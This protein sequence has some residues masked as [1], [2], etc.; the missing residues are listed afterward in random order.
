MNTIPH[1]MVHWTKGEDPTRNV[2][3]PDK[4][5]RGHS[6]VEMG[7]SSKIQ[8][9]SFYAL[10]QSIGQSVVLEP[11]HAEE[12][13]RIMGYMERLSD[14]VHSELPADALDEFTESIYNDISE[15]K[16]SPI[17]SSTIITVMMDI[18]N[19]YPV[20]CDNYHETTRRVYISTLM[21]IW[22]SCMF[23][24]DG[25]SGFLDAAMA[26]VDVFVGVCFTKDS[27]RY[28]E[29]NKEILVCMREEAG[30][31]NLLL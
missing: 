5:P 9:T 24:R 21:D 22:T 2:L 7:T 11:L 10:T 27:V 18:E 15:P 28:M 4:Q 19:Y 31:Q 14:M 23:T 29:A 17:Y 13:I 26:V 30:K 20:L 8:T 12:F 16:V 3:D 25:M 6:I 1:S